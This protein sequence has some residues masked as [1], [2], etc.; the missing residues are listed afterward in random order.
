[1]QQVKNRATP[2]R[3][4]RGTAILKTS[5]TR[6]FSIAMTRKKRTKLYPSCRQEQGLTLLGSCQLI[7]TI[8]KSSWKWPIRKFAR[9]D[10]SRLTTWSTQSQQSH[11]AGKWGAKTLIF[12]LCGASWRLSSRISWCHPFRWSRTR[13]PKSS[14]PSEKN[15]S[16]GSSKLS[17][18]VR[19]S[20][21]RF[22]WAISWRLST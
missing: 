4:L 15:S 2:R 10:F 21:H 13:W 22:A 1:M 17:A 20:S 14:W 12:T 11:S 19:S 5:L 16:K 6:R 9:A 7:S 8:T 18:E 3:A